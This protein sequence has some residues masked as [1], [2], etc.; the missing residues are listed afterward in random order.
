[1]KTK[2]LHILNGDGT[3]YGFKDAGISGDVAIW[4]ETLC[5]GPVN[6]PFASPE[7]WAMRAF[8]LDKTYSDLFDGEKLPDYNKLVV[9]EFEKIQ[10]FREYDEVILWFEHD[11]FCQVNLLALLAWFAEQDMGTTQLS[12]ICIECHPKYPKFKGL[13]ELAPEDFIPLFKHKED[14]TAKT[15]KFAKSKW[16]SYCS[17]DLAGLMDDM[18]LATVYKLPFLERAMAMHLLRFPSLENGLTVPEIGLMQMLKRE[19]KT[20]RQVVGE[21]LREDRLFGYGD[22][23]YFKLLKRLKPLMEDTEVKYINDLGEKVLEGDQDFL[24]INKEN[25]WIGGASNQAYRWSIKEKRLVPRK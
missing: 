18:E 22:L 25:I 13:G 15:L 1:M 19:P 4:R 2:T 20:G 8:Y 6:E 14:L 12:L 11:L 5:S 3:A 9:R 16:K 21:A 24:D 10:K 23:E 17:P 7:F